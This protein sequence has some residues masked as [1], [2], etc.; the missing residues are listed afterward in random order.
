MKIFENR[1][2]KISVSRKYKSDNKMTIKMSKINFYR[3][4]LTSL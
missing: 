1:F 2:H 4:Y 3:R